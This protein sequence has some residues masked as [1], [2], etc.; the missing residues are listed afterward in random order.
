M[1]QQTRAA[2][3]NESRLNIGALGFYC[4]QPLR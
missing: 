3:I 1:G 2:A 4:S